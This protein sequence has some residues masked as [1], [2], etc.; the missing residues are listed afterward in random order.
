MSQMSI[1]EGEERACYGAYKPFEYA[2]DEKISM[3][4]STKP[5]KLLYPEQSLH[6]KLRSCI[7]D[8][9]HAVRLPNTDEKPNVDHDVFGL[10]LPKAIVLGEVAA[11]APRSRSFSGPLPSP[12]PQIA[13]I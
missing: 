13:C 2:S 8:A 5:S 12:I 9:A 6:M 1:V 4:L 11:F 7:A 3:D 10:L